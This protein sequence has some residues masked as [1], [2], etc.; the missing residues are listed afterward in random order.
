MKKRILFTVFVLLQLGYFTCGIL[1][2]KGKI[3]KGR[4]IILKVNPRDPYSPVRGRYLYVTYTISDLPSHL[5]EGGKREIQRG[6]WVYVV[7]EEKGNVWEA[8]KIVRE[9]PESGVFIKGKVKY[10]LQGKIHL[11]YGIEGIFMDEDRC[12]KLNTLL[13][14]GFRRG[15][16][17]SYFYVEVS[18]DKE[19]RAYPTGIIVKGKSYSVTPFR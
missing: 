5:L 16:R 14:S 1:Y 17:P 9:K 3:E 12:E 2:H 15:Q 19:G 13:S 7:L 8:K 18:V 6:E 10:T 11:E 4:K